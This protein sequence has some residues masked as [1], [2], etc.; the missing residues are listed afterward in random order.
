MIYCIYKTNPTPTTYKAK[1]NLFFELFVYLQNMVSSSAFE[2][3]LNLQTLD[4][5]KPLQ[6]SSM[7]S[8]SEACHQWGF[9][10]I[11]NHG[12]S[13]DLFENIK[14]FSN[15]LFDLPSEV[16]LKLGPSSSIKTYTPQFIASPYFESFRVS[17][18]DFHSSA[19]GSV[20]VVFN[21]NNRHEFGY[22]SMFV[23]LVFL[24]L[25]TILLI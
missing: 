4:L 10:N 3:T 14:S 12:I 6:P 9:F 20:D 1:I 8:L 11:V 5:S 18:P 17:G 15:Q 19:Q 21:D 2:T 25:S 7:S 22:G 13:K 24:F 23:V 16:K